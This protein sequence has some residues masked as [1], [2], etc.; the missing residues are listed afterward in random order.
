MA[1]ATCVASLN[2]EGRED[3]GEG[4]RE[5]ASRAS[6]LARR[7]LVMRVDGEAISAV[8]DE[9]CE[10]LNASELPDARLLVAF[11]KELGTAVSDFPPAVR[12]EERGRKAQV[13]LCAVLE[14]GGDPEAKVTVCPERPVLCSL[15]RK[16]RPSRWQA[17][18]T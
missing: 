12:G 15:L 11:V 10:T 8:V 2:A 5:L 18:S 16:R 4:L 9:I 6:L 13:R 1:L 7:S 17:R 14:R 3:L